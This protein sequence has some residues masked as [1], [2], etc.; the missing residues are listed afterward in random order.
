VREPAR[1]R[2]DVQRAVPDVSPVIEDHPGAVAV[3]RVDV[4]DH[5]PLRTRG[6]PASPWSTPRTSSAGTD[7]GHQEPEGD[8]DGEEF[9]HDDA[10]GA[11]RRLRGTLPAGTGRR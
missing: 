9:H 3:V 1:A 11:V 7:V 2:I 6:R 8:P 4:D 10:V 5:Y